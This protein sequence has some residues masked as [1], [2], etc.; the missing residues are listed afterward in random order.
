M[1]RQVPHGFVIEPFVESDAVRAAELEQVLFADQDPWSQEQ[2][3]DYLGA[4][5]VQLWA[6]RAAA[7][8]PGL[9]G[10][11]GQD[12]AAGPLLGYAV[13]ARLGPTDDPEF[14]LYDIAVDPAHQGAGLGRALL[15]ELLAVADA[16]GAPVFLEVAT[17]NVPART[18]Y[19]AHGFRAVGMRP[20]YYHPSG[21]SAYSMVR[22]ARPA[23]P[24]TTAE[25]EPRR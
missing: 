24:V 19:E 16:A 21:E 6:V 15:R 25:E 23:D 17:G 20:N 18:L 5:H 1:A 22:P 4:A 10:A 12:G 8:T 2:F 13:L 9:A 3:R 14:E 11:A 7:S